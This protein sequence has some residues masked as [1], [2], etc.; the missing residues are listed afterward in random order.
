[1]GILGVHEQRMSGARQI[2]KSYLLGKT[3]DDK[4]R[5]QRQIDAPAQQIE[6]LV[7]ELYWLTEEDIRIVK[8]NS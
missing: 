8:S 6:R 7:Y 2:I 4:T 1:M 3:P 5:L